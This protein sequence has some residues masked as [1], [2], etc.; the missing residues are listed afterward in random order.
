MHLTRSRGK[1]RAVCTLRYAA[2]SRPFVEVSSFG[3]FRLF[4]SLTGTVKINCN[5]NILID[6]RLNVSRHSP[7]LASVIVY[8]V[9][10]LRSAGLP[11][12]SGSETS[13]D[14]FMLDNCPILSRNNCDR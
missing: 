2:F 4:V 6:L 1:A 12:L 5:I 3:V 7:Y 9:L 13:W 11:V 8:E 10:H 14:D